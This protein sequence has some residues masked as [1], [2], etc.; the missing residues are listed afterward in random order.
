MP[1]AELPQLLLVLL[2]PPGFGHR[3]RGGGRTHSRSGGCHV[4]PRPG[5]FPPLPGEAGECPQR[6]RPAPVIPGPDPHLRPLRPAS[7][8]E[9]F[10]PGPS[11]LPP[12]GQAG[13]RREPAGGRR[14]GGGLP[15]PSAAL[16]RQQ[17]TQRPP[18][19]A[20]KGGG[21]GGSGEGRYL[22][23]AA[24]QRSAAAGISGC[25]VGPGRRA[26]AG[27]GRAARRMGVSAGTER[28]CVNTSGPVLRGRR[29]LRRGGPGPSSPHHEGEEVK[30]AV[31]A[32]RPGAP[33]APRGAG[34]VEQQPGP[35]ELGPGRPIGLG[36]RE[37]RG[38]KGGRL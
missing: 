29:G 2:Q 4:R 5:A 15:C 1:P 36:L 10:S 33:G 27:A 9:L 26:K 22:A 21:G 20:T 37:G 8:G 16:R 7:P 3:R 24:G 13:A 25:P 19:T 28:G 34:R 23:A 6:G 18:G 30:R 17:E 12:A 31:T 35:A 14:G 38:S 11:A 32:S